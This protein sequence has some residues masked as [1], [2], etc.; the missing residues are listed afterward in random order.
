MAVFATLWLERSFVRVGMTVQAGLELHILVTGRTAGHI[1]LVAFLA[2]DLDV[3]TGQ[4]IPGLGMIKLLC[5]LPVR[6]IMTLQAIVSELT[7]VH[8]FVA[9]DTFLRQ[10]EKGPRQILH[11][12]ECPLVGNHINGQV[13]FLAGDA[14]VLS[15]QVVASQAMIKLFLRR[16]PVDEV[17]VFAIVF[18]VAAHTI[19]PIRI[20]HLK[21]GVISMIRSE[22]LGHFFVTIQA[23]ESRSAGAELM[24]TGALRGSG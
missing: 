10:T 7:F 5:R 9:W 21:L 8:I 3:K 22:P 4:W 1:R 20:A 19:F 23:F 13:A 15:F 24:T 11:S 17:E 12:D 2:F 14:S 16:L 18:E 6:K